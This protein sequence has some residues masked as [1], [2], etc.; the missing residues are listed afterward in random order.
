[1][2]ESYDLSRRNTAL[3]VIY[4]HQKAGRVD[5]FNRCPGQD[6]RNLTVDLFKCQNCG[7]ETEIFSNE[8]RAKCDRCGSWVY[9]EQMPSCIDWCPAAKECVGSDRWLEMKGN[10]DCSSN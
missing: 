1:M 4:S 9:K 8:V 2:L 10:L 6:T 7:N 3:S 5:M